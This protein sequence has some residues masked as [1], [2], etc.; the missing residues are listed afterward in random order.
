MKILII[1]LAGIGDTLLATPLI[2]ALRFQRPNAVIDV[3]TRWRGSRDLLEGNAAVDQ[4]HQ[5]DLVNSG[6]FSNLKFLAS[7]RRER[8]DVSINTHPQGKIQYRMIARLTGG[9][10]RLSHRYEN[11]SVFDR[12]LV[13]RTIPQDYDIHC[14]ENSLRLLPLMGLEEPKEVFDCDIFFSKE[15]TAWAQNFIQSRQ[16]GPR[17]RLGIHVGSGKTKNLMLKRWPVENYIA[18]L[19]KLI[20]AHPAVSVFLFGGPEEKEENTRILAEVNHPN[21][22]S[23]PSNTMKEA[24]ALLAHCQLFLSVDNVFMHLA[25][26]VKVPE[27]IVI[28]SP[29]FNKTIEPYHRP[30]R[31]VPNPMV[32]G[33]SLNYYRYD[34]RDIQGGTKHLLAVMRSVTAEAVLEKVNA[35]IAAIEKQ[36]T[37][38]RL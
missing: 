20:P 14:A 36:G 29:T 23:V 13:N 6:L 16:L 3:L 35:A 37:Q 28:E 7:L 24:A 38:L 17:V 11:H 31:L 21:L 33:R 22:L 10:L 32:A 34:G 12:L 18:L 30:Y 15:E 2:R 4:V 5:Q 9:R 27:Q 8:Y 19:K 25:A 26:S 1:S